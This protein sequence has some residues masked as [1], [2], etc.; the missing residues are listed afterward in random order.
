VIV[1]ISE[2][3]LGNQILQLAGALT[4]ARTGERV[5]LAGFAEIPRN[6]NHPQA[7]FILR[8]L[9]SHRLT[10]RFPGLLRGAMGRLA[11]W[12]LITDV[13]V[14][15][16]S[17]SFTRN[18][19]LL[20]PLAFVTETFMQIGGLA[21]P[22]WV[23]SIYE[24]A[25]EY[26]EK[27]LFEGEYFFI[28]VRRGDFLHWPSSEFPAALPISWFEEALR[29]L[30]SKAPQN[31]VIVLSDDTK[32]ARKQSFLTGTLILELT[33]VEAWV[34]M[35]EAEGGILS[36]SSLSF[37]ASIVSHNRS[38][39]SDLLYAPKYWIGW[40]QKKWYPISIQSSHLTYLDVI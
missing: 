28:H 17:R 37:S 27:K 25:R 35:C 34:K 21:K 6:W 33:A 7:V 5:L 9:D 2:G 20:T 11:G 18:N 14:D 31:P 30:R 4:A 15:H 36:A 22:H 8:N 12:K 26:D 38:H 19:G 3:R 1:A 13:N 24:A 29:Q 10:R 40:P 16:G 23:Q 39:R 32:W